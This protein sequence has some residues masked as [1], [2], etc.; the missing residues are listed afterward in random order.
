MIFSSTSVIFAIAPSVAIQCF[1]CDR[2]CSTSYCRLEGFI[3]YFN[4]CSHMFLLMMISLIRYSTV[5]QL[6]IRNRRFDQHSYL[7]VVFCWSC[8]SLFA[9]PP[10]FNWNEYIPEGIG[11]HCGLN[12]FDRSFSS[13]LYFLFTFLGVYFIPLIVLFV[14]NIYIY[15]LIRRLL[16]GSDMSMIKS[17]IVLRLSD[18]RYQFPFFSSSSSDTGHGTATPSDRFGFILS[19]NSVYGNSRYVV[20]HTTNALDLSRLVRLNRL[21]ADR[22][23]AMATIFLVSEYLLSWTPYALVAI[24]Y[25]FDVKFFSEQPILMTICAFIAKISM[26]LN[27]FIYVATVN[28]NQL[29]SILYLKKCSCSSCRKKLVNSAQC[30]RWI[31]VTSSSFFSLLTHWHVLRERTSRC[32]SYW[33]SRASAAQIFKGDTDHWLS[34][35]VKRLLIW[36]SVAE[37]RW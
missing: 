27:P 36:I 25:L 11:F 29:D 21:N 26:I 28:T 14:V 37:I 12:W 30:V 17:N 10:L 4:G 18:Y 5:H 34:E 9:V 6:H 19:T 33:L 32:C 8:A 2:W 35:Q 31:N 16:K 20:R 13:R 22:R 1:S 7:A 24:L 15:C 23:F 3:S